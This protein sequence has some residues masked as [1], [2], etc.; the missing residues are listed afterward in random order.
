MESALLAMPEIQ[1]RPPALPAPVKTRKRVKKCN[2]PAISRAMP[3]TMAS[4]E[5]RAWLMAKF[6]IGRNAAQK[7][8]QRLVST[9]A[10]IRDENSNYTPKPQ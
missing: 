6:N 8:M 4:A 2:Y 3:G 7:R 10:V 5:L 9:A 1:T